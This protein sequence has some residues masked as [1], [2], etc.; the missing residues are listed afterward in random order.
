MYS[1]ELTERGKIIIAVII[2]LLLLVVPSIVLAVNAWSNTAPPPEEPPRTSIPEQDETPAIIEPLPDGSGFD[3]TPPP[4]T[5]GE[6]PDYIEP[7]PDPEKEPDEDPD[8]EPEFGLMSVDRS[9]GTMQFTFSPDQ[10]A[11]LDTET[12]SAIGE[13]VASPRN[14]SNTQIVVEIPHLSN[15]DSPVFISALTEAF[16]QHGISQDKLTY[17]PYGSTAYERV[18]EVK[19]SYRQATNQK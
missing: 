8:E 17:V 2:V 13:F 18:F 1:Y 14:R 12:L 19:L 7:I 16:A 3:P 5:N 4:E 6:D 9:A 15:E 11:S 10:Q